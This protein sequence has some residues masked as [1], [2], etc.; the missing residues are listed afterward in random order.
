[1]ENR[2]RLN[3]VDSL[4]GIAILLVM[5]V[6]ASYHVANKP[7]YT[8]YI[9]D[10]GQ[11]GVQLFFVMSALT[12]CI[13][14]NNSEINKT[15]TYKF[16]IRR[17]FR[18]APLYYFAIPFYMLYSAADNFLTIKHFVISPQYTFANISANIF[19]I[20][21]FISDANS[22]IV[23]GGWSIGTEMAFYVIFPILFLIMNNKILY[24]RILFAIS[25]LV[26]S[27]S[28]VTW[29]NSQN[30]YQNDP[31]LY[32][33]LINQIPV[34]IFGIFYFTMI[35]FD[36]RKYLIESKVASAVLSL[37]FTVISII[38]FNVYYQISVVPI[39]CGITFIFYLDLFKHYD[40]L[41]SKYLV[42]I[43]QLSFSMYIFHFG[44]A[45][46]IAKI[47]NQLLMNYLHPNIVLFICYSITI[48]GAAFLAS[49]SEK[50]IEKPGIKLGK[51]LIGKLDTNI[52]SI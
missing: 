27:I 42:R 20:H 1:M 15:N 38:Q 3:Y 34:F 45:G 36:N 14:F 35:K 5:L 19:F 25:I 49:I 43:G 40:I 8:T 51:I 32:F 10:F 50:Y 41:N 37:V 31:F 13:S 46:P 28:A 29:I 22:S 24:K 52:K 4:R 47:T 18:I 7:W 44:F 21:G 6:H 16:F 23:K 26:V 11:M 39:L 12:L 2:E 17:F 48:A 33:N 30:H 9:T